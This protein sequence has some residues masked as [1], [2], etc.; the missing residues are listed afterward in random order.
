M[1][2][3]TVKRPFKIQGAAFCAYRFVR[4]PESEPGSSKDSEHE[5]DNPNY[6]EGKYTGPDGGGSTGHSVS[7]SGA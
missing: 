1:R 2:S 6:Q 5:I 3:K 7:R 4:Q